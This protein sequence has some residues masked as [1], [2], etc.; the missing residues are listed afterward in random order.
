MT[1]GACS[2]GRTAGVLPSWRHAWMT[3]A[4]SASVA[5]SPQACARHGSDE[6]VSVGL[7]INVAAAL[8]TAATSLL[9]QGTVVQV[10]HYSP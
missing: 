10:P 5:L 6:L 1:R 8:A 3:C 4:R 2:L 7:V 9:P